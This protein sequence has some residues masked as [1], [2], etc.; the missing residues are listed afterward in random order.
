MLHSALVRALATARV[1][2]QLRA[3]ARWR[4]IGRARRVASES[5]VAATSTA[6]Q[7]RNRF[8]SLQMR[9]ISGRV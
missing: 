4:A 1:E 7:V 9:A 3:A 8:S 2:D 5:R 6:S